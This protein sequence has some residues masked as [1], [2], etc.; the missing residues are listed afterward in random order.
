MSLPKTLAAVASIAAPLLLVAFKSYTRSRASDQ[1]AASPVPSDC[2]HALHTRSGRPFIKIN[3]DLS[4]ASIKHVV[5]EVVPH[6]R[7]VPDGQMTVVVV[8]GGIT[9]QLFKVE[10]RAGGPSVLVRIFGAEGMID[11]DIENPTFEAIADYFKRPHYYGRFGNGRVEGWLEGTRPLRMQPLDMAEASTSACI[12][13]QLA[14]MHSM[15]LP[16]HL[17]EFYQEPGLWPQLWAWH[18]AAVDPTTA[19]TVGERTDFDT[20]PNGGPEM[21]AGLNLQRAE[22]ELRSLQAAIPPSAPTAFCHNDLLA[23][24][25][26]LDEE[27]GQVTLIDFE[28]GGKNFRGFDIANHFN[29]W[30]GGT[31]DG[32]PDY[33]LFPTPDQQ[34]HFCR[35]YLAHI[36]P[37]HTEEELEALLLETALFV[38]VD[39]WYWGLW[40][41]NQAR[42]EGCGEFPYLSYAQARL[43]QY[44]SLCS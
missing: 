22:E 32:K 37:G 14:T 29:E 31:A 27:T 6:A 43:T 16:L 30:A 15:P 1:A 41:V 44:W 7:G 42:D 21:L 34:R 9:N 24:N 11:R 26:M 33:R 36:Q 25:I 40:A 4:L 3:C 23:G 8:K 17:Q 35:A 10:F 39:H 28:Y 19:K 5:R 20:E 18:R 38:K 13:Q 12:A 2:G